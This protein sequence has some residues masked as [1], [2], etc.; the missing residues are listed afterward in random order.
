MVARCNTMI[1]ILTGMAVNSSWTSP[2]SADRE[3]CQISRLGDCKGVHLV[4]G[5]LKRPESYTTAL[6]EG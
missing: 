3:V 5:M 1:L 4:F 2:Y 6:Y